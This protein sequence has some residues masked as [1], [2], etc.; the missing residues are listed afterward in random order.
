MVQGEAK[1]D[2]VSV[3]RNGKSLG[4][5]DKP[6]LVG[7]AVLNI[8]LQDVQTVFLSGL[9]GANGGKG[10]IFFHGDHFRGGGRVGVIYRLEAVRLNFQGTLGKRLGMRIYLLYCF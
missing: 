1:A 8:F 7:G 3:I 4:D 6:G 10:R 9:P 2:F 5:G